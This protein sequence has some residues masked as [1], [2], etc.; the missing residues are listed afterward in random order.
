MHGAGARGLAIDR[1]ALRVPAEI[2]DMGVY[3]LE[4][5]DLE[6]SGSAA[7]SE[8]RYQWK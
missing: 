5:R 2:G 8:V 6:R 3:P 1:D 4:G 7:V